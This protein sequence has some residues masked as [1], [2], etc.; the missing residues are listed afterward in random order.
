ML[1]PGD[2]GGSCELQA[3]FTPPFQWVAALTGRSPAGETLL[4]LAVDKVC[5]QGKLLEVAY[6]L[7]LESSSVGA[8]VSGG[9]IDAGQEPAFHSICCA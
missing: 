6:P 1:S 4:E 2:L 7:W 8:E 5:I 9:D 3:A